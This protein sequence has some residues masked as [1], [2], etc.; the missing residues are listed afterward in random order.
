FEKTVHDFGEVG[1]EKKYTGQFTFANTGDALLRI[2]EVKK[3]CGAV[4]T[5]DKKELA[6]GETGVLKVQYSS[7]RGSGAVRK[8]LHVSSNDEANP[9]VTL[10][11]KARIVPKVDYEPKRI[12]LVLNEENSGCP[13]IT[14]TSLDKQPFSITSFQSNGES[15]TADIDPA[16]EATKFVLQPKVDLEKL[17]KRSAGFVA[18]GLTHPELSRVNIYF[19]TLLRFKSTPGSIILFNPEPQEPTI[20]RISVAT[21][22]NEEFEVESTSSEEGLL[23]VLSQ[24]KTDKGYR[25]EVEVTPPPRDDTGRFTDVL[26]LHLNDGEKLSIKCYGRYA[27]LKE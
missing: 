19:S 23:K 6:P 4:V 14:V 17:Q 18:I 2:T 12:Q 26:Y 13:K 8:Q 11:I 7:G 10:T 24:E 15:I 20:K 25:L 21:N 27:A 22:Y 3:C 16:V 5:L 9:K 1:S